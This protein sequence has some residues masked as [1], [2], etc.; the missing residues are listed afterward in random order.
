MSFLSMAVTAV[1]AVHQAL[2]Q[3]FMEESGRLCMTLWA[4]KLRQGDSSKRLGPM[5]C[6]PEVI[7]VMSDEA[8]ELDVSKGHR[9]GSEPFQFTDA[10][11]HLVLIQSSRGGTKSLQLSSG[12]LL[13]VSTVSRISSC[14]LAKPS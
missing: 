12:V 14:W 10:P 9:M 6:G 4:C 3:P 13:V 11:F 2:P 8:R 5:T 1:S 7:P